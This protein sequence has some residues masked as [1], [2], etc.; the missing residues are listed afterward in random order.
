M[1]FEF[2]KQKGD[3]MITSYRDHA[4]IIMSGIDPMPKRIELSSGNF[5]FYHECQGDR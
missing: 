5:S 1:G 2:A 3:S 4:H